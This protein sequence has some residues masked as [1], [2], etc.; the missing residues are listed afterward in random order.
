MKADRIADELQ[1]RIRSGKLA[2]GA[3]VPS[4][5]ALARRWKVSTTTAAHALRLLRERGAVRALPRSGTV[6]AGVPEL[7]GGLSRERIV[8]VAI[9]AAD[10]EGLEGLS[11]R[12]VA[13]KL[14]APVMSL[15]RHV[16]GKDELLRAMV[17]AALVEMPLPEPPPTGWRAQLELSARLE[18]KLMRKHPWLARQVHLSRPSASPGA[19]GF[20]NWVF[21]ALD[22][23]ALNE[24][25]KL[26]LHATL[27]GF[28]QGLA[29]NVEAE[30]NAMA[31]TGLSEEEH[32]AQEEAGFAALAASGRYPYFLRMLREIDEPFELELDRVFELGLQALLD[33]FAPRIDAKRGTLRVRRGS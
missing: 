8:R 2:P 13:A 21:R 14:D 27:H 29:V 1:Q 24:V 16:K 30:A 25:G 32:M 4:T 11:L 9:Q 18:W 23:T 19:L 6:V 15:Y 12:G 17:D 20:A 28:V 31:S 22:G 3:K 7:P 33:G 10:A 5:R 26:E